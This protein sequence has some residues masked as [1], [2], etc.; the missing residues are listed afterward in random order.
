MR[1][2]IAIAASEPSS[3][4]QAQAPQLHLCVGH[5]AQMPDSNTYQ[6]HRQSGPQAG[7]YPGPEPSEEDSSGHILSVK[8]HAQVE[9]LSGKADKEYCRSRTP[10]NPAVC[11]NRSPCSVPIFIQVNFII[12][13]Q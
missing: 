9:E 11:I 5:S 12:L 13:P 4:S 8:E 6:I 7:H 3:A 1:Q 2:V 10:Q